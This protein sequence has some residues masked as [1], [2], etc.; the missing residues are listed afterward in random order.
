MSVDSFTG[1]AAG[2]GV[3]SLFGEKHSG[4]LRADGASCLRLPSSAQKKASR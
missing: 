4:V 2:C 3:E 1:Q